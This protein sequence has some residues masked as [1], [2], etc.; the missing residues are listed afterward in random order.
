MPRGMIETPAVQSNDTMSAPASA[1]FL[2]QISET[3]DWQAEPYPTEWIPPIDD[4][5]GDIRYLV[6]SRNFGRE[7]RNMVIDYAEYL[8]DRIPKGRSEVETSFSKSQVMPRL[9]LDSLSLMAR[10]Q[11]Y[12]SDAVKKGRRSPETFDDLKKILALKRDMK[13]DIASY[14]GLNPDKD[15]RIL[16]NNL[17]SMMNHSRRLLYNDE[18]IEQAAIVD[19]CRTLF[20]MLAENKV[21]SALKEDKWPAANHA[22]VEQDSAGADVVIPTGEGPRTAVVLQVKSHNGTDGRLYIYPNHHTHKVV[23]PMNLLLHDPFR[24]S[25]DGANELNNFISWAPRTR[26]PAAA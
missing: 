20:G 18:V 21:V 23:V 11:N 4:L 8:R 1:D 17:M 14:V 3:Y 5:S 26:L 12:H 9:F 7:R 25:H 22:T 19:N 24:M 6:Q 10:H 2:S 16:F 13:D 15:S